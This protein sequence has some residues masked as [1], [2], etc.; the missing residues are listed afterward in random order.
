[1]KRKM[2]VKIMRNTFFFERRWLENVAA[3]AEMIVQE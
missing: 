3:I 2:K 1:M